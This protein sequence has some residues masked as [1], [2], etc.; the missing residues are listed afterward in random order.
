MNGGLAHRLAMGERNCGCHLGRPVGAVVYI[1]WDVVFGG[2]FDSGADIILRLVLVWL[3]IVDPPFYRPGRRG[4][5]VN[6]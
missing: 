6:P 4:I 5:R 2:N 1:R 3:I